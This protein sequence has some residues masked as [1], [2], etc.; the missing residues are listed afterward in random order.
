MTA[1]PFLQGN[2]VCLMALQEQHCGQKMVDWINDKEVTE[3]L[4]RGMRP[5]TLQSVAQEMGQYLS[6]SGD[7]VLAICAREGN[8]YVGVAGLHDI[9]AV[10]RSAEFRILIGEKGYW[11]KG[12]G[13]EAS[14]LVVAYG[15]EFLNLNKVWLGANARNQRALDSYRSSGFVEEGRLRQESFRSGRYDDVIRMSLLHNEY[16][17]ARPTWKA[18]PYIQEQ[19]CALR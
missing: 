10:T 3:F 14:Q 11:R 18:L 8:E 15:F 1:Q 4:F 5:A 16:L 9:N 19:L 13:A 12:F 2:L 17:D 7:V 6:A